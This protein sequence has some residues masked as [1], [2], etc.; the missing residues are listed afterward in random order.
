MRAARQEGKGK[1]GFAVEIF[2]RKLH[3]GLDH[4]ELVGG[5]MF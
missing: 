5:E 1:A 3:N 2:D 4:R